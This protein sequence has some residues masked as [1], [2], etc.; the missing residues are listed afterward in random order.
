MYS[1]GQRSDTTIVDEPLYAHYLCSTSAKEYHPGSKEVL[2]FQENNG[3]KAVKNMMSD[4]FET[5]VVFFKHMTHH[6]INLDKSF[7]KETENI[8]LTRDPKEMITSF[9]KQIPNPVITDTG[10][11]QH[12]ELLNYLAEIGKSPLIVDSKD[13]L[14]NPKKKLTELCSYLNI[15]FQDA[16]LKWEAGPR[17]EDGVW[18]KYWYHNVHKSKDFQLYQAKNEPIPES[19]MSLYQE[20]DRIYKQL[21]SDNK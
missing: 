6:L 17:K 3:E 12:L 8:I 20:C 1:F 14:L 15:P 7:L 11:P 18:A 19:L 13:L 10:Y 5:P 16:M 2:L 9:I 21:I 4:V